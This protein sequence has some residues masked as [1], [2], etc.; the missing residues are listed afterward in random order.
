MKK[1]KTNRGFSIANFKDHYGAECS[2]QKSSLATEDCI[3]FGIDEVKP[4]LMASDA[5]KLGVIGASKATTGWVSYPI[6]KEVQLSSRMHLNQ[7]QVKA[8]LPTLIKFS[9]T[10]E[11]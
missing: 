6:P 8:L 1:T 11:I 10:G 4:E 9:E 7:E 5:I 2:L 3:W